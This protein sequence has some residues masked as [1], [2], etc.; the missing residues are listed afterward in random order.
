MATHGLCDA[1]WTE[2]LFA[3]FCER[4]TPGNVKD[5]CR[6]SCKVCYGKV[7]VSLKKSW[8]L[9][10]SNTIPMSNL[11]TWYTIT[12]YLQTFL[13]LQPH[14][15]L[16]IVIAN[17]A[18]PQTGSNLLERQTRWKNVHRNVFIKT[19]MPNSSHI[20]LYHHHLD[21]INVA[22]TKIVL[23]QAHTVINRVMELKVVAIISVAVM[24][25]FT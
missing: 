12:M 11:L 13:I 1:R 15:F 17:S 2:N 20:L 18:N 24:R 10:L 23:R 7:P 8:Q 6:K 25:T 22:V 14:F 16:Y 5:N 19:P 3:P 4:S 21:H 9:L